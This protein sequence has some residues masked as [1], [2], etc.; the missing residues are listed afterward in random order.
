MRLLCSKDRKWGVRMKQVRRYG[1]VLML[2]MLIFTIGCSEEK[3]QVYKNMDFTLE[4]QHGN[5]LKL[6]DQDGKIRLI[7]FLFT[8]CK[9]TC[10]ATTALMIKLQD[11]MQ[12]EGLWGKD[13]HFYTVTFDPERDTGEALQ[14]YA[15][16]WEM[17]LNYWSLVRGSVEDTRAVAQDFGVAVVE[18]ED[19]FIHGDFAFLIDQKG[20]IRKYYTGSKLDVQQVMKDMKSLRKEK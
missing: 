5:P 15:E 8:S 13:T 12:K 1:I 2:L 18:V 6:S 19:D 9:T 14:K 16:K 10:V 7:T 20:N 4:D 17:D 3:L 11:E